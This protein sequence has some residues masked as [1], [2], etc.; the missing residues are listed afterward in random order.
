MCTANP[1]FPQYSVDYKQNPKDPNSPA[2][3]NPNLIQ[4]SAPAKFSAQ[5]YSAKS[6]GAPSYGAP[7]YGVPPQFGAPAQFPAQPKIDYTGM[8]YLRF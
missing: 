6:Y 7:S 2:Y 3:E 5:P 1:H 4:F 8:S